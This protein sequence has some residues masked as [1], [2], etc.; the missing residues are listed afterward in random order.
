MGITEGAV[1][2]TKWNCKTRGYIKRTLCH[3]QN[4]RAQIEYMGA[5]IL[6]GATKP[7]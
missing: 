2:S 7:G 3:Q 1:Y 4:C 5:G 6:D